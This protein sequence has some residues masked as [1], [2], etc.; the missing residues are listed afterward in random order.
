MLL[1][2][3]LEVISLRGQVLS[4]PV[5]LSESHAVTLHHPVLLVSLS[6]AISIVPKFE[7]GFRVQIARIFY[8]LMFLS[9]EIIKTTF[10]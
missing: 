6:S 4:S 2:L 10:I 9:I 7:L 3:G 5:F 8:Y 1:L